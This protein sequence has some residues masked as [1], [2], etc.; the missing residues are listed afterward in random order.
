MGSSRDRDGQGVRP[1][2]GSA[3]GTQVGRRS[4]KD[5]FVRGHS[6][7]CAQSRLFQH[8]E[9]ELNASGAETCPVQPD[10]ANR[11]GYKVSDVS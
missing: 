4:H 7:A 9:H 3:W 2:Q 11:G 5:S 6:F 8:P 1:G 10:I